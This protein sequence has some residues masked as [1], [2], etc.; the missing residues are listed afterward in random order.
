MAAFPA[1]AF[2]CSRVALPN[3]TR[4]VRDARLKGGLLTMRLSLV[5]PHPEEPTEG[6]RLEGSH[7]EERPKAASPTIA[8]RSTP[9]VRP[10]SSFTGTTF[11]ADRSFSAFAF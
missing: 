3:D 6:R 2:D 10:R 11:Y 4:M 1:L 8:T 7:R 5:L 9:F